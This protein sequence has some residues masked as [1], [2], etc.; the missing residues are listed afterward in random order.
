MF[1]CV[2]GEHLYPIVFLF[3]FVTESPHL[4]SAYFK[5]FL[6]DG[7]PNRKLF[8]LF[9]PGFLIR[10]FFAKNVDVGFHFWAGNARAPK[11]HIWKH[12]WKVRCYVVSG[13]TASTILQQSGNFFLDQRVTF[14]FIAI[15]FCP[16]AINKLF[17]Y[18]CCICFTII[19]TKMIMSLIL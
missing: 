11:L 15:I 2:S 8:S 17:V 3:L 10:K 18:F 14:T 7:W 12:E 5:Y 4:S 1:I 19:I 6:K 9:L 16:W 13:S